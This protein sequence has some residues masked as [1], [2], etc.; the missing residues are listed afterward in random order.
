MRLSSSNPGELSA[1]WDAPGETARDYRVSWAK[2]G[3]AFRTWTDLD[4]NAFPTA[5]SLTI[6]GLEGG[7]RY[8]VMVRARYDGGAGPWTGEVETT[9]MAEETL[10]STNTA[11][12]PTNTAIPATN[13]AIPATNTTIPATNTLV[14]PTITA[15]PAT[16]TA[17]P[18]TNTA[19]PPT[20]TAVPPTNTSVPNVGPREIESVVLNGDPNGAIDVGWSVPS[21][22]PVDYRINWAAEGEGY[23][24]WTDSNGNAFPVA[25]AYTIAGLDLD[26]CYKVRVRARYGGSAGGWIEAQGKINGAC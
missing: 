19:I 26:V 1:E 25:N 8:K 9:V 12:A 24:S 20:N 21:E 11:I 18:A 3:E 15:I 14:P 13:T 5:A 22:Y 10:P 16:S 23:P 17:I 4:Y 7:S 2:V 6:S